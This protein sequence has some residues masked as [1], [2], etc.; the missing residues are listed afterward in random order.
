MAASKENAWFDMIN[1]QTRQ[2]ICGIAKVRV[3]IK[4]TANKVFIR[5]DVVGHSS[6][7]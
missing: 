4:I 6:S 1:A 5:A 7:S 2:R 3:G